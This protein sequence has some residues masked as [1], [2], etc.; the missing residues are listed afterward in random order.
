MDTIKEEFWTSFLHKHK[1]FQDSLMNITSTLSFSCIGPLSEVIMNCS[2]FL[3][4]YSKELF[5]ISEDSN[6]H[7]KSLEKTWKYPIVLRYSQ[8][9]LKRFESIEESLQLI[10]ARTIEINCIAV[11][12]YKGITEDEISVNIGEKLEIRDG[13]YHD[14][15]CKIIKA[16]GKIGFLPSNCVRIFKYATVLTEAQGHY[17]I[18]SFTVEE[19]IQKFVKINITIKGFLTVIKEITKKNQFNKEI[20]RI[21]SK[22]F[23]ILKIHSLFISEN[24]EKIE[25]TLKD[26]IAYLSLY[27]DLFNLIVTFVQITSEELTKFFDCISLCEEIVRHI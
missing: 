14:H 6:I 16:D 9:S 23:D 25:N 13:R 15:W 11:N 18:K 7:I 21:E 2:E 22:L 24:P 8:N 27:L 10:R 20:L 5:E 4:K 12:C 3:I 1:E 19:I 17:D 26:Y